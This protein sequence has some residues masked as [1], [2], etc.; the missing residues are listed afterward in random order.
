[1]R[2]TPELPG[3]EELRPLLT[4][5]IPPNPAFTPVRWGY[6][7]TPE[8]GGYEQTS[9]GL[10]LQTRVWHAEHWQQLTPAQ[11]RSL[12]RIFEIMV[13]ELQPYQG[14]TP[15]QDAEMDEAERRHRRTAYRALDKAILKAIRLGIRDHPLIQEWYAVTARR[16]DR[17]TLRRAKIG[18]EKGVKPP[19]PYAE[20]KLEVTIIDLYKAGMHL[21]E[22]HRTL[23]AQHAMRPMSWQAFHKWVTRRGLV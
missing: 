11:Q 14:M 23:Q 21:Q 5:R 20:A 8:V 18:L 10:Y 16:G 17:E 6:A 4:A 22:I 3:W 15:D 7:D 1:M 12:A 13:V 19:L 2:E 9:V